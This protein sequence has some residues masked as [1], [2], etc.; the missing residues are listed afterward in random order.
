LRKIV[1]QP[2]SPAWASASVNDPSTESVPAAGGAAVQVAVTAMPIRYGRLYGP[3]SGTINDGRR[4]DL[5][6]EG[7]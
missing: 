4:I 3:Y 1:M 7:S 2:S 5:L 6:R